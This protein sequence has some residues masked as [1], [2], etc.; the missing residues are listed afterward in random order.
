MLS[1][2]RGYVGKNKR[3]FKR[4]IKENR[5]KKW[6]SDG[7]MECEKRKGEGESEMRGDGRALVGE[8]KWIMNGE[9]E[10]T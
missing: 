9:R 10:K 2:H 6:I 4:L 1:R 5:E 8:K 7:W 3:R